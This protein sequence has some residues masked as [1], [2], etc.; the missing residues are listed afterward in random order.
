MMAMVVRAA[1]E[2]ARI[3]RTR[4][5]YVRMG[6]ASA[7]LQLHDAVRAAFPN[8]AIAGGYGSTEAGPT[9]LGPLP[10]RPLPD[11][12][13]L[14]WPLPGVE[15][16]L[17]DAAGREADEGELWLRSPATMT[18]YLNLPE[19]TREVLDEDGWYRS[20]DVFRRSAAGCFYF[21][22]RVDDRFKC[23]GESVY[24]GEVEHVIERMP[25]VMQAC[26][27]PVAD[28][29]KGT[30]P[31]AFVVPTE[32]AD[33]T[34]REVRDFVLANAPAYLHPRRVFF[35][36]A[37]PLAGTNKIDRRFLQFEAERRVAAAPGGSDAPSA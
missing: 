22:G 17:V 8:A 33:V 18:G 29:I 27:V 23:D 4:M 21:V 13:G 3:D 32:G 6:S 15:A 10:G 16:R 19:K 25:A 1:E 35:L 31:V 9:L 24:P 5:R 20:G 26:V 36:P 2:L 37:L 28:E 11:D 12:G 7:T 14:G 30:K 34:E